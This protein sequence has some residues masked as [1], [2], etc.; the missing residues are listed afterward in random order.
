MKIYLVGGAV[1]DKLL[2]LPVADKDW[3]VVGATPSE[4]VQLGYRQVGHDFPVFLHP[5]TQEE[6]ALAR[7][8][9]KVGKGYR[10]FI[11]HFSPNTTLEEDLIRRDL[12]INAIAENEQGD[13][14]DPYHGVRD[15]EHKL[16][17]HISPAFREDPLRVLRVARFASRFHYLGF[18]VAPET[19]ALMK[20]MVSSGDINHL[21]AERIWQETEKALRT[22]DPQIYFSLLQSCGALAIL[23]PEIASLFQPSQSKTTT[24]KENAGTQMLVAL[25]YCAALTQDITC[26]FAM[27]CHTFANGALA[28]KSTNAEGTLMIRTLCARLKTPTRFE[29]VAIFV[30]QYYNKIPKILSL[31]AN[32]VLQLLNDIDV[33]RHPKRLEQLVI[34]SEA[35]YK[36]NSSN[37]TILYSQA[38]YFALLYQA[39]NSI[40]IS[41][42]VAQGFKKTAIKYEIEASREKAIQKCIN[43]LIKK[44]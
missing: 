35:A 3:V 21:S 30:Q 7:T 39:A 9:R 5:L 20:E 8:E 44:C 22:T 15:L 43:Y 36:A 11:C 32:E 1:R 27:L 19:L 23:F 4:L 18:R 37:H 24:A 31:S 16:L 14:I 41:E 40:N 34:C 17:R 2:H 42:I 13:L 12:T 26:R 38:N 6:Y 10:G 33:W 28:V 29:N 25:K